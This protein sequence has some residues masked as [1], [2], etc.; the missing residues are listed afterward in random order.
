MYNSVVRVW[1]RIEEAITRLTRNQFAGKPARGFESLRLRFIYI[2]D[3]IM[4]KEL[5]VQCLKSTQYVLEEWWMKNP[6]PFIEAMDQNILWIAS[7]KE[8][9]YSGK[10]ECIKHCTVKDDIPNVYLQGQEYSVIHSDKNTCVVAGRYMGYTEEGA[11]MVLCETQRVTFIWK[12]ENMK[13]SIIHLHLSNPLHI[14]EENE[15]FPRKAGIDTGKYLD[16]LLRDWRR[17]ERLIFTSSE[18]KEYFLPIL[19]IVYVKADGEYCIIGTIDREILALKSFKEVTEN[20]ASEFVQIHR[21]VVANIIYIRQLEP[22][23]VTMFNGLKL[24][25]ARRRLGAVRWAVREG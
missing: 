4:K 13:L 1:R 11:D 25:V 19:D 14:L 3:K 17:R 10:A 21:S 5:Q 9:Y 18:H 23:A 6:G 24:P 2:Q 8:E 7:G 12:W 22:G 16:R 15:D 20:L